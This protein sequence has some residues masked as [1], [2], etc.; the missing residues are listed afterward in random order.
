MV[1]TA[2]VTAASEKQPQRQEMIQM[3]SFIEIAITTESDS[4]TTTAIATIAISITFIVMYFGIVIDY[5][6]SLL[7][8]NTI[9]SY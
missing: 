4:T 8:T 5:A 2:V 7:S 6:I 3:N 1:K 9:Q